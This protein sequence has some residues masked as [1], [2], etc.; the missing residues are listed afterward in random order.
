MRGWFRS[1]DWSA[2]AQRDFEARLKR[3]RPHKRAQYLRIKALALRQAN[4][5]DDAADLL[6]RIT[7]EYADQW[8]EVALAHELL[9]DLS[10]IAGD[11]HNAEA[12]YRQ[13]LLISPNLNWTTREVYLKLGEVLYESGSGDPQE[14]EEMLE[15]A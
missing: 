8:T 4:E 1:S 15:A 5:I 2:S 9:G 14:L 10:R 3:A 12:E 7:S 13:S 11:L 6:R